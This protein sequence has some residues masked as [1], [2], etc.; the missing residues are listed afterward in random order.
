MTENNTGIRNRKGKQY[1]VCKTCV[2]A[3]MYPR[4][5]ASY[6]KIRE[7]RKAQGLPTRASKRFD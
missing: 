2:N 5:K 3:Y 7:A 6:Q 1:K 4:T